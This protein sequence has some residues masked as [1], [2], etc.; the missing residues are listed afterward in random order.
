[1][2]VKNSHVNKTD[3]VRNEFWYERFNVADVSS[4][5]ISKPKI[6]MVMMIAKTPSL[7]ASDLPVVNLCFLEIKITNIN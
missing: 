6:I 4:F 7:D 3:D 5:G 2:L 1:M